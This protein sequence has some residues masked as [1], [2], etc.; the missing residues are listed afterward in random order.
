[1]QYFLWYIHVGT[2][3]GLIQYL[4]SANMHTFCTPCLDLYRCL[5]AEFS[6]GSANLFVID[7]IHN[8]SCFSKSVHKNHYENLTCPKW[9]FLVVYTNKMGHQGAF[10][11]I[12]KGSYKGNLCAVK[13]LHHHATISQSLKQ[14]Y[15]FVSYAGL[16]ENGGLLLLHM[17]AR[18]TYCTMSDKVQ[19]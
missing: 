6:C 11:M 1:M 7:Y 13:V 2:C 10:I 12:L 4:Q 15:S 5:Q 16:E 8:L 17:H 3:I 18:N 14:I 9:F 19:K